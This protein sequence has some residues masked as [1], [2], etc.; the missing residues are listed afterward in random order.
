MRVEHRNSGPGRNINSVV[1]H[2]FKR[3]MIGGRRNLLP[4]LTQIKVSSLLLFQFFLGGYGVLFVGSV[5][6]VLLFH[7]SVVSLIHP[8]AEVV[9][10]G[11]L[12]DL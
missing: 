4:S 11:S 9:G 5:F 1:N 8:F 12:N 7:S 2:K 10:E 3:S 6:L